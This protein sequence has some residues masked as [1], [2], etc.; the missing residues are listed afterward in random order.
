MPKL[1]V[2][3]SL[4]AK[5]QVA[6]YTRKDGVV[7]QAHDNGRMAAAP[8]APAGRNN[9]APA[10]RASNSAK[11]ASG[12]QP[13][14]KSLLY[15]NTTRSVHQHLL[16]H[17]DDLKSKGYKVVHEHHETNGIGDDNSAAARNLHSHYFMENG[18]G[19]KAIAYRNQTSAFG[20]DFD[21]RHYQ[22]VGVKYGGDLPDVSKKRA[23]ALKSPW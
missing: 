23:K 12:K 3:A 13:K 5:S 21:D 14:D 1:V 18:K 11:G 16:S 10:A 17:V 22:E 9:A 2:S 15:M 20:G 8:K 4:L 19:E 7:V 6:Q